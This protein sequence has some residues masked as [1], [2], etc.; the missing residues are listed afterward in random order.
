MALIFNEHHFLT[1]AISISDKIYEARHKL[2]NLHPKPIVEAEIPATYFSNVKQDINT[3]ALVEIL[4]SAPNSP[5]TPHFQNFN[6]NIQFQTFQ[7]KFENRV[8]DLSSLT[9]ANLRYHAMQQNVIH[10]Q[11]NQNFNTS[12]LNTAQAYSNI[13]P[14]STNSNTSGYLSHSSQI[15]SLN[16]SGGS[17]SM[18]HPYAPYTPHFQLEEIKT[19]R[20][21]PMENQIFV[22]NSTNLTGHLKEDVRK[23]F[24]ENRLMTSHFPSV[25]IKN[26]ILSFIYYKKCISIF[27]I[28][29]D[30]WARRSKHELQFFFNLK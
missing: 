20:Y 10:Q 11:I 12:M 2:L 8:N 4:S 16:I 30:I 28:V 25:S 6:P 18:E 29:V 24:E 1:Y 5:L 22:E 15:G 27:L 13:S 26:F 23:L 19:N 7:N 9:P 14:R 17:N 21:S 3:S